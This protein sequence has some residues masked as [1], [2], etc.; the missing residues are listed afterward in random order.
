MALNKILS[1]ILD[2]FNNK[3]GFMNLSSDKTYE[4]LVNYLIVSKIHPEAFQDVGELKNI[5]VD[6]GSMFGIDS[7]AFIVNENLVL[8]KDDISIYAKSKNLDVKII[9]IQTKTEEDYNT[10]KILKTTN[11]VKS[12]FG[13]RKLLEIN[14]SINNAYEIYE[15]LYKYDNVKYFNSHSPECFVYYVTAAKKCTED[16]IFNLI[17]AEEKNI[18]SIAEELKAVHVE[19]LGSD[20]VID[21]YNEVEN[22]IEV[23]INFKNN[24]SLD[25]IGKV[26]QSYLGYLAG[27]EYL[28][29]ITDNHGNLRRRLFYENVRDYQGI[30]NPVNKEIKETITNPDSRDKFILLN[31]GITIV[32]KHFKSLGSNSYEMRDFQIV[33][34]CQTSNEIYNSKDFAS[35]ILVPVKIIHTTDPDLI[36][37]IV[38]ATNRQT[39]VPDEAFVALDNYNKRL[40]EI[41]ESYSKDMPI[42]L[43]YERRSGELKFQERELKNF[44][45]VT[46]HSLIRAVISVYFQDAYIVYNNNPVNILRN[47]KDKLFREDHKHEIYYVS[48]YL[49][50]KYTSLI[51]HKKINS[52][53]Y[54][55]RF[56]VIMV[57]R[58]LL[59]N[60]IKIYQL[61]SLNIEKEAK[62]IIKL[63]KSDDLYI[64]NVYKMARDLVLTAMDDFSRHNTFS[65]QK[66][67]LRSPRFN[68]LVNSMT[69]EYMLRRSQQT[70]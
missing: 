51:N 22:R 9:F 70:S 59:E 28:K 3:V 69:K 1:S 24:L 61:N 58:S 44:Q 42:E 63:L 18:M 10:G 21:S 11:A 49:L 14:D 5:D 12:F 62:R 41:F 46:L 68:E 35:E 30:N 29:I 15:E 67:V 52:D 6:S 37:K 16:L 48:N 31:N 47:R 13:D 60:E 64:E 2:D 27:D 7:V 34:G 56:Y 32:V 19:I 55:L 4:Y 40:Q 54:A 33:N 25:R 65:S 53:D 26:E 8:N 66:D 39:P 23:N 57:V 38:K 50:A 20:Y 17:E 43:Y 45:I 36:S